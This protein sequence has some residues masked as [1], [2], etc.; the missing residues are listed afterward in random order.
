MAERYAEE[1]EEPP[2]PPRQLTAIVLA[3]DS[4]LGASA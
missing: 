3:L 4:G 2:L 1:G